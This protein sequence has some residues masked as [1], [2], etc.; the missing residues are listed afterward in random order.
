MQQALYYS[1]INDEARAET[2]A[3]EAVQYG[4]IWG[5]GQKVLDD[6]KRAPREK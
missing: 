1:F 2:F 5:N 3:Q 4:D 6:I